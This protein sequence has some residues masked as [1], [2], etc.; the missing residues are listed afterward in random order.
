MTTEKTNDDQVIDEK[1]PVSPVKKKKEKKKKREK[2]R[3]IAL[4]SQLLL[5]YQEGSSKKDLLTFINSKAMELMNVDATK[6][7]I[8]KKGGGF[9]WELQE[10]GSGHGVLSS[11]IETLDL[12]DHAVIK[13]SSKIARISRKRNGT[14]IE[15]YFLNEDETQEQS[16]TISYSDKMKNLSSSG[17]GWMVTGLIAAPLGILAVLGSFGFKYGVL[18][19]KSTAELENIQQLVPYSQFDKMKRVIE[20]KTT[21]IETIEYNAAKNT[22]LIKTGEEPID[23]I[24]ESDDAPE[25]PDEIKEGLNN[26]NKGEG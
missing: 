25:L 5:G 24:E 20:L 6:Y 26:E 7:N 11:V 18:D 2:V 13:T 3:S 1:L 12:N 15:Q 16:D 21:Y 22:Y 23:E 4:P 19:K 9:Y 14:G 17:T 8:I 10:G